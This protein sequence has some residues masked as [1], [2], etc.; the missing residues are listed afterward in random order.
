[1]ARKKSLWSELQH[2]RERRQRVAQA[3][4]RMNEQ[5]IK[6]IGDIH[7]SGPGCRC[8]DTTVR[9]A[10]VQG[11]AR[12]MECPPP[13]RPWRAADLGKSGQMNTPKQAYPFPRARIG[14]PAQLRL[15][16]PVTGKLPWLN[17]RLAVVAR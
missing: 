5:T 3:R 8:D 15:Y 17:I 11:H 6:Q 1:M 16:D 13:G 7:L 4:E 9:V 12:S 10:P 2:E 14:G